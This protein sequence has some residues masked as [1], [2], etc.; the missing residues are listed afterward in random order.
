V[1]S[2]RVYF[3]R[4][5]ARRVS[6]TL[7]R[8]REAFFEDPPPSAFGQS[9]AEVLE[10]LGSLLL[11]EE[12]RNE[13]TI[14]RYLWEERFD[15]RTVRVEV[16]PVSLV[17]GGG[18]IGKRVIDLRVSYAFART[19]SDTLLVMLPRFG[20]RF[21]L[22]DL[23][24]APEIIRQ[25][26]AASLLGESPKWIYD[27]RTDGAEYVRP[28]E[29]P[30]SLR[31][32]RGED[33]AEVGSAP[34]EVLG[35]IAEELVGLA[36]K[37][38]LP[39]RVGVDATLEQNLPL[40]ERDVLPSIV[41]VGPSGVGKTSFVRALAQHF[42]AVRRGKRGRRR[43]VCIWSTS[44]QRIVAGMVYLGMWQRRCLKL[45]EEL[46]HE[47]DYLY[48]DRLVELLA[49]QPD[50]GS[51]ADLLG[52][53]IRAREISLIV[54]CDESELARAREKNLAF[55]DELRI[56][57][58]AE[59]EPAPLYEL[60]QR[61]GEA[62][63]GKVAIGPEALRRLAA[64]LRAF[65]PGVS[66]PGKAI[67]FLEWLVAAGDPTA[68]R[69]I[70]SPRDAAEVFSRYSGLP[71]ELISDEVP[72]TAEAIAGRLARG[73]VGQP[74]ACRS[75]ARAIA[76]FKAGL[77]DPARPVATLFFAGPT[78]V[79]KTELAKQL[80]VYLFGDARR[81]LRIDM[82][83]YMTWGSSQ[84]LLAVGPQVTSLA[85]RVRAEPFSVVLLDE[86]EKAH[87]EVFDLLL[88]VLGEG[89]L[90]DELGRLVDFRMTVIVMTSNLGAG[91]A[92][93]VGFDPAGVKES[94][95]KS[96]VM[97][98]FRPEFVG[99]LDEI[100]AFGALGPRDI[101]GIVDLT[102]AEVSR[103]PGFGARG[104]VLSLSD[105]ARD[106]LAALG[107]DEKLGA[108]PL[109]RVIEER[110]VT[111]LA[112][113]LAADPGYRDRRVRLVTADPGPDDLVV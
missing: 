30:L 12:A 113:R 22:E 36:E 91:A 108:R 45:V 90:T 77:N 61:Y 66:F 48:A 72:V 68:R 80:A 1:K 81:L 67:Q 95:R 9:E 8:R 92:P 23:D 18:V 39:L 63:G 112:A 88:G 19:A 24:I 15:V 99:R 16:H 38:K 33:G 93:R 25:T 21:I 65:R 55:V 6:G 51:I 14:E 86:I 71:V 102:L 74:A 53:A 101:A 107:H 26:I 17:K 110:V 4:H 73:V 7:M 64:L 94:V 89:R 42:L 105:A 40:F 27:Y 57:R 47:G 29:L 35:E 96:D 60:M 111:P 43:N 56:V 28:W 34:G 3:V 41:L 87:A 54:E 69:R 44:A 82:S 103:R 2:L 78:G 37:K 84:R 62:R 32:G 106:R 85:T 98:H 58:L 49:P 20:W 10:Q 79:G 76:R 50:G 97:R 46:S 100:V 11:L 109:K 104:I 70:A 31:H 83:E 52:P 5:G 75:T 13:G 59:M